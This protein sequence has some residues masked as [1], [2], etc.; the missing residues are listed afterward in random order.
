MDTNLHLFT[1]NGGSY[2]IESTVYVAQVSTD[3]TFH[4][5]ISIKFFKF[6]T[7]RGKGAII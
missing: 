7:F 1:D 2:N 5:T 6:Y 4:N 3:E